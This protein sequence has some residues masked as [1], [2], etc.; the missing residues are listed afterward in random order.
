MSP[1][2]PSPFITVAIASYNYASRLPVAFEAIRRQSF[3]DCEVLYVDDC[4]T[5]NS[6]GV[7]Q[8]FI[9]ENPDMDIRL[10]KNERNM[11]IVYSKN[12]LLD[13][14]RGRY[15]ML[16]DADDWME[17]DCLETLAGIARETGAD[18]IIPQVR[19][20]GIDGNLIQI[21]DFDEAQSKWLWNIHHGV[22]YKMSVIREHD[23]RIQAIPDDD[24]FSTEFNLHAEKT[25]FVR[26]PLYSWLV[27][28]DSAGRK[29]LF[30]NRF[31]EMLKSYMDFIKFVSAK[32]KYLESLGESNGIFEASRKKESISAFSLLMLKIYYY[33]ILGELKNVPF[34]R[35]LK[36]Y[37]LLHRNMV[38][39]YGDYLKNPFLSFFSRSPMR[40]YATRIVRSCAFFE[41]IRIMK[42]VL[43]L[44]SIICKFVTFDQ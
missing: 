1:E 4:S 42:P 39:V 9:R 17:D 10:L 21:Q 12:R 23:I 5:D 2:T 29:L 37:D 11:G 18:R 8:G 36:A 27:H 35:Q 6:A 7:I 31:D 15:V 16:C 33:V 20:V 24:Y 32:V 28:N 26:K 19:D 30:D 43:F 3:R 38:S 22:L 41:K 34:S 40:P 14:A 13:N 25:V 44:Y